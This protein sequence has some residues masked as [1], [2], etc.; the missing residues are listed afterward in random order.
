MTTNKKKVGE[1]YYET[2]NVKNKNRERKK[3]K[4]PK[5]QT[6]KID[7]KNGLPVRSKKSRALM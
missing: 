5:Y 3:A 1:H 2:A 7:I 6:M 4:K